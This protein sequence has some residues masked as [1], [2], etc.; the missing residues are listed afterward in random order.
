MEPLENS[1]KE[2]L[3]SSATVNDK[4]S[5]YSSQ[6]LLSDIAKKQQFFRQLAILWLHDS[7]SFRDE[8]K[9]LMLPNYE[10]TVYVTDVPAGEHLLSARVGDDEELLGIDAKRIFV[11][12]Y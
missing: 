9:L 3:S 2:Y 7:A 10:L 6:E 12:I 8:D 11:N 1:L 5:H 4:L